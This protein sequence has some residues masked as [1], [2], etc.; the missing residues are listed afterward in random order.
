[1]QDV[2]TGSGTDSLASGFLIHGMNILER[3]Y[4]FTCMIL[5]AIAACL[6]DRKFGH[7]ALWSVIAAALTFI[8]LMHAYQL[9]SNELDFLFAFTTPHEGAFAYR[10][11]ELGIAYLAMAAMFLAGSRLRE[12]PAHGA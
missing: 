11:S 8:G 4:I 9:R 1:M 6:I 2:L 3:G 5:A 7:A 12:A 10:A